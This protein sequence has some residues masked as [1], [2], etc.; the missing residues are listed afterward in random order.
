[1]AGGKDSPYRAIWTFGELPA[2]LADRPAVPCE[3]AFDLFHLSRGKDEDKGVG[4]TLTFKTGRWDPAREGDYRQ[5]RDR[6]SPDPQV[7]DRLAEKYGI[8]EVSRIVSTSHVYVIDLPRGLF[9][10]A[11]APVPPE[12]ANTL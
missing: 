7:L 6:Q 12:A 8:Y 4:C 9:K 10:N 1:I 11:L 5:E 2:H 3:F